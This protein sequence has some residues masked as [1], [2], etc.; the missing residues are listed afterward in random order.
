M[1]VYAYI[2]IDGNAGTVIADT[3]RS[4][5]EALR[6]RGLTVRCI[7]PSR[8]APS[9]SLS[10]GILR[11]RTEA[12]TVALIRDW[13][14]LLAIGTSI[15]ETLDTSIDQLSGSLRANVQNLRDDVANGLSLAEA[16]QRQPR[17]FDELCVHIVEVGENTGSL[18]DALEQLADFK[19]RTHQFR[20]KVLGALLY[21]AIVFAMAIGVSVFLMTVVV[22]RLLNNLV[23]AGQTVPLITQVVKVISDF[24]LDG[25]WAILIAVLLLT[26]FTTALLRTEKGL[27]L[28]HR[29]LLRLP[30]IGSMTR[31]QAIVRMAIILATLLRSGVEFVHALGIVGRITPNRVLRKALADCQQA[32]TG[33]REIAPALDTTRVFPPT[34]IQVFSVGQQSGEL[35]KMLERL[36]RNYDNQL[37]TAT[38]R[39]TTILE[40]LLILVMV[41]IVGVIAF[42]TILPMLEASNAL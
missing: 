40:P 20:N 24:M 32:I 17:L 19:E 1:P 30:L 18:P 26:L 23:E 33:G 21:P 35:E 5:R 39:L 36:A 3:P 25:W 38:H 2:A 28:F 8:T 15:L 42:A 22:P 29:L 4:A 9:K 6:S 13:A 7:K 34:V 27:Y 14:T 37:N 11:R 31:K 10:I 41:A 16:M 12:K